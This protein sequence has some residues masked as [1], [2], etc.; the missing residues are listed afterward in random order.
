MFYVELRRDEREKRLTLRT[1]IRIPIMVNVE[2]P[3]AKFKEQVTEVLRLSS[4]QDLSQ[5]LEVPLDLQHGDLACTAAFHLAQSLKKSPVEIA[6]K[7][8]IFDPSR[9]PLIEQVVAQGPYINFYINIIPYRRLVIDAIQAGGQNY[10]QSQLFTGNHVVVEYPAVN[11][12]NPL[13]IG[14]ARN[15]V[16]GDTTAR[17]LRTVGYDV[18]RIDYINDLGLQIAV[19]YWALKHLDASQ[20]KGKYDQIIGRL[21]VEAQQKYDESQV[22]NYLKLMEEGNNEVAAEV[23]K[24]SER[25]LRAHHKT[26]DQLNVYHDLL[27]WESDIAHSGLFA[28]ALEKILA[29]PT[30]SQ[31]SKGE[32]AGCVIVDLSA[33]EEFQRLKDTEKVLVRSDGVAT[34][35]GKDIAFHFWKFGIIKDPF[36]YKPFQSP[37]TRNHVLWTTSQRGET[38]HY[39]P[40][41][42]IY[43]VIGMPQSQEQRTVYLI[44]K[45][46]GYE[47]ASANYYHLAY[48]YVTLPE[49][50][51]SGRKGTWIGF[52]TDA[53]IR[54]A[55]RRARNEVKK[56]NPE[57]SAQFLRQVAEAIG[58]AAV[59]YSLLK[60]AVEKQIIFKWED[61]LNFD[62]NAAPYLMYTHARASSI[63]RKET[64][65]TKARISELTSPFETELI[66]LLGRFPAVILEIVQ[67]IKREVWGTRI[68]LFHLTEYAYS[69]CVAFNSFYNHC[70]VLKAE[71]PALVEARLLLVELC[72][73]VLSNALDLLGIRSLE[74]I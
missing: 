67:G 60:V 44:L 58:S 51:F 61:M 54:E 31:P 12:N 48:E 30:T 73:Q 3:W 10:G 45:S 13:H 1:L 5:Y 8:A 2:N 55:T 43:N 32:K 15:A 26:H 28:K 6:K 39:H 59:R 52:S 4:G 20:Y 22:R 7:F 41:D 62:G 35:T 25:V 9:F 66:K 33:Y 47:K 29:A 19:A 72:R 24:M 65:P 18:T 68:E 17:L 42:I 40:A 46:L 49:A 50:K 34:Y 74:R 27:I 71:T 70:P 14:H 56:R 21:Y 69:L 23:R 63:L 38:S 11:P 36:K 64:A 16:L 57:A 53:V 37:K